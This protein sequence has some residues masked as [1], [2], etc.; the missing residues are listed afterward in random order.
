MQGD[1]G[2]SVGIKDR[3]ASVRAKG[4]CDV[5]PAAVSEGV[6]DGCDEVR[7]QVSVPDISPE[8]ARRVRAR[9]TAKPEL[10]AL[11]RGIGWIIPFHQGDGNV[12][13]DQDRKS[14]R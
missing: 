10:N 13:R 1:G 2:L 8:G 9:Q 6:C 5:L 12:R 4:E 14:T 3:V 7:L 11:R